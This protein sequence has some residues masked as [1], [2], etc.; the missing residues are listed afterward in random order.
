[1]PPVYSLRGICAYKLQ[2][3]V[4]DV[5]QVRHTVTVLCDQGKN[6]H[7]CWGSSQLL[8]YPC[9]SNCTPPPSVNTNKREHKRDGI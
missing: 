5:G 8:A 1:M 3:I 2:I 9:Y 7:K 4:T 6:E